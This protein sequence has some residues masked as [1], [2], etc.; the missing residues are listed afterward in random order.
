MSVLEIG[1]VLA[2]AYFLLLL[3]L[4]L[5]IWKVQP[6]MD[7][8]VTLHIGRDERRITR[9]LYGFDYN[10]KLYVASNHWV[11]RWYYA[12]IDKAEIEVERAGNVTRRTAVLIDGDEESEVSREY[13]QGL[14]LRIMCGFAPQRF[15]RLDALAE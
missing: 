10:G 3:I 2:A 1:I 11:R 4:E 9:K 12:A 8:M 5:T 7:G 14:L 13:G 15:L 6:D